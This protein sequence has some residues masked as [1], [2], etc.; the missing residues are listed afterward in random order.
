MK[1]I[2]YSIITLGICL[3]FILLFTSQ[4]T[5]KHVETIET[6]KTPEELWAIITRMAHDSSTSQFPNT[7]M[8]LNANELTL[9]K[10]ILVEY[11]LPFKNSKSNYDITFLRYGIIEMKNKQGPFSEKAGISVI[12]RQH[13][14]AVSWSIEYTYRLLNP[15]GWYGAYVFFPKF[16]SQ[17]EFH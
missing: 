16:F 2:R 1:Q 8:N 5:Y 13:G 3:L 12:P 7:L 9:H 14:S 15:L 17:L 11:K 4:R 6:K 10:P